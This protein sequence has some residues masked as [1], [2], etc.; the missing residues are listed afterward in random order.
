MREVRNGN[1]LRTAAADLA[2]RLPPAG[3]V[4][5]LG[6][7]KEGLALAAVIT[8][9]RTHAPTFWAPLELRSGPQQISDGVRVFVV[10][11][12]DGGRGWRKLVGLAYPDAEVLIPPR[13]LALAA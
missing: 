2:R 3:S 10:E 6:G 12:V 9:C 1:V 13:R 4:L 8:A 5:L 7:S 11:P